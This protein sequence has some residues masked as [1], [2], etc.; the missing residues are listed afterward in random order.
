V[1]ARIAVVY[2]QPT[3]CRYHSAGEE[4]AVTGVLE[5]VEAVYYALQELD[6]DV[7]RVP[8]APPVEQAK[9]QLSKLDVDLVF[10][11]FEGFCGCP[12]TEAD[13]PDI[14]LAL[15]MPYTGSPGASLRLALDKVKTKILLKANGINTPDFQ[16]LD[17]RNIAN[18]NLHYPCIVKPSAE[19][20][21]HG[22]SEESVVYDSAS[23]REQLADFKRYYTGKALV[24]EFI[25]GR[26]FNITVI[27]NS[28]L[29]A[30]PIS[31]IDYL[32]PQWKPKILTF[33]AKWQPD[34]LYFKGTKVICPAEIE[35]ES[36]EQITETALAVFS[37][38][39]CR[40]Y[41]RVDM[42]LGDGGQLYVI[43]VNPNPDISPGSGA[44]RQAEAAGLSYNQFIKKI[45]ELVLE[46]EED[47]NQYSTNGKG[48]QASLDGD[49]TEYARVQ[50][51]R[52]G[53][54]RR[55][56]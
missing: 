55:G 25:N 8:L 41:A 27:G 35:D 56:H 40:G 32:L 26:E 30:L 2:N 50:A 38:L 6:Y 46:K 24:E 10:N 21:S 51:F 53:S 52:G 54:S 15:G 19:D 3:Y 9:D 31:E 45:V 47:V 22:L 49:T 11:L 36:R 13:I 7:V 20:A 4:V 34:S 37:L 23:L 17:T 44:V 28:R 5:A 29:T 48:R 12:E 43:E 39:G 14:L 33:D 1:C 16:L 18:F 42:R